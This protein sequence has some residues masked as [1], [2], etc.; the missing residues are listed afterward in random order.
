MPID[1]N[2]EVA[3]K[4]RERFEF[5]FVG[6]I[7]T[8]LGLSIQTARFVQAIIPDG[9]EL[10]AW[11]SLLVSGFMGLIRIEW[12][13]IAHQYISKEKGL[14]KEIDEINIHKETGTKNLPGVDGE[15]SVDKL[16]KNKTWA[17]EKVGANLKNVENKLSCSYKIRKWLFL[18]GIILLVLARGII[19]ANGLMIKYLHV[20]LPGTNVVREEKMFPEEKLSV[21]RNYLRI[22]FADFDL[23]DQYDFDRIAQTFR[24]VKDQKIHLIT[25]SKNFIDDHATSELST[26]LAISNLKQY[27]DDEKVSRIVL[28]KKGIQ[29]EKS[30]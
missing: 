18:A 22:E 19:P 29:T 30:N 2:I 24:L 20:G 11:L 27:F 15:I 13:P 6:L 25:V 1:L 5:Y 26:H 10:L 8:I 12:T 21:I 14:S 23:A 17:L 7:F 4:Y 28:T 9:F 16:L 3:Q